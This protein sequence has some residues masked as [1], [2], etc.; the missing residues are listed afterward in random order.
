MIRSAVLLAAPLAAMLA[1]TASASTGAADRAWS[2]DVYLDDSRIGYHDYRLVESRDGSVRLE[3]EASF[4][5]RIL[6]INAF[7]YRHEIE[8][9]WS[10]DCLT[11]VVAKTNSNGKRTEVVGE[12]TEQGFTVSTGE[13]ER[14]LAECVMTFAY[15]NPAFLEQPRLLNPQTGEFVDVEVELL[16]NE[17]LPLSRKAEQA[18]CYLVRARNMEVRVWYSPDAEWLALESP[19]KGGR[20]IRYER[21]T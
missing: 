19:T 17:P 15:W 2:F 14:A 10:G 5:V 6:F 8:E 12:L 13:E 1:V 11:G 4:N 20:K 9:T 16:G 7:R 21:R 18:R 3:A